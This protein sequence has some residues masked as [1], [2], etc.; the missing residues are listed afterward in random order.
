[1]Q[2]WKVH[3]ELGR[4]CAPY[5][6]R[7][8]PSTGS[9]PEIPSRT[10]ARERKSKDS[11]GTNAMM[12]HHENLVTI[13]PSP[14][15]LL[16]IYSSEHSGNMG[17]GCTFFCFF[18]WSFLYTYG[19]VHGHFLTDKVLIIDTRIFQLC[20]LSKEFLELVHLTKKS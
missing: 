20:S 8:F 17:L 18:I 13:G 9:I 16:P 12:V 11:S 2:N 3:C 1:M 15:T 10:C 7:L 4:V 5:I 19:E 14:C 6:T